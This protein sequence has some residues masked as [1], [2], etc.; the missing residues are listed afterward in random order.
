MLV[1]TG[2]HGKN[3]C[4]QGKSRCIDSG[5][6]HVYITVL[7]FDGSLIDSGCGTILYLKAHR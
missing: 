5:Y 7:L 2:F 6:L 3:A 4:F 1:S